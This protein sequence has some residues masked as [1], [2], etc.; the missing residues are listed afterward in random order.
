MEK[1]VEKFEKF[2]KEEEWKYKITKKGKNKRIFE[3][4]INLDDTIGSLRM[5]IS[6][7]KFDYVVI[8]VINNKATVKKRK[9][10]AEYLHRANYGIK[11]GNFEM[12]YN[13]GEIRY[14][15]YVNFENTD[16]SQDVL[17]E[18]IYIPIAMFKRYGDGLLQTMLTGVVAQ[19]D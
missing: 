9:V 8:A 10:V 14:K 7:T 6:L 1:M 2:F 17:S 18:S 3:F 19:V 4:G 15:T 11:C 5:F 13:D 12:D 16:I